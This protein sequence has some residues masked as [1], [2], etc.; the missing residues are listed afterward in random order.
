MTKVLVVED[1]LAN[2]ILLRWILNYAGYSEVT[3]AGDG[4]TAYKQALKE[5]YDLIIMD[6]KLPGIS[7]AEVAEKLKSNLFLAQTPIICV[8]A[9]V[10]NF[11]V[12]GTKVP[13]FDAYISKPF[14][15]KELIGCVQYLLKINQL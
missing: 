6:V 13:V 15:V 10:Y 7:G 5:N 14:R 1:D 11:E 12:Q 2:S 8:S 4:E 3:E 9:L